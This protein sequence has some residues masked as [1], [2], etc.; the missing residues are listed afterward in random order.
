MITGSGNSG[1]GPNGTLFSGTFNN[2]VTVTGTFSNGT[3]P[4][5]LQGGVSG[6]WANGMATGVTVGTTFSSNKNLFGGP[7][8]FGSGDT[9][10]SSVPE[11]GTLG[12]LGAGLVGLAG[13][14][15]RKPGA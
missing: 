11:P 10:I 13:A 9:S 8:K 14:V 6:T 1:N 7:I 12:L 4:Y 15:R 5:A 3:Y 2:A